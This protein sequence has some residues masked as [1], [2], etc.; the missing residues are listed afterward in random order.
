RPK[1]HENQ[2]DDLIQ[3]H[4]RRIFPLLHRRRLFADVEHFLFFDFNLLSG[5]K[6]ENVF[7]YSN[8]LDD[9]RGLIIYHNKFGDTRGWIK[10]S[11]PSLDKSSGRLKRSQLAEGLNLPKSGY[12]IFKDYASQ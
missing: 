10:N 3:A 11:L 1:M 9:E 2:D 6:D 8:R 12:V 7:A 5:G 4:Q